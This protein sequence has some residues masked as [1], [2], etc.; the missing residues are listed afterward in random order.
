MRRVLTAG[1]RVAVLEVESGQGSRVELL[2][3]EDLDFSLASNEK[4]VLVMPGPG[5]VYSPVTQGADAGYVYVLLDRN[6]VAK[7]PVVYG[8][9]I[10]KEPEE[11]PGFFEK[12][13]GRK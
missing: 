6:A 5:F 3:A 7:V 4:P 12:L 2:A 9:T 1:E 11:E 8:Q 13:F 10:E